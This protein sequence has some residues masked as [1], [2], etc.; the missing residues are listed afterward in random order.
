MTQHSARGILSLAFTPGDAVGLYAWVRIIPGASAYPL[1]PLLIQVVA[2]EVCGDFSWWVRSDF[3]IR[4]SMK[5]CKGKIKAFV[6]ARLIA[7]ED[8]NHT[9][10]VWFASRSPD[11]SCPV[12]YLMPT[13][14]L[15]RRRRYLMI[16][17]MIY[18]YIAPGIRRDH[19]VLY[20]S[21]DKNIEDNKHSIHHQIS[22]AA[23]A[24]LQAA[25]ERVAAFPEPLSLLAAVAL[26]VPCGNFVIKPGDKKAT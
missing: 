19:K 24:R 12:M 5:N 1:R 14:S 21:A 10:R 4:G 6:V 8:K 17:I 26:G 11:T 9:S 23:P 25:Q 20:I 13:G 2:R 16:M 15:K 7:N 3:Q 18:I 22:A